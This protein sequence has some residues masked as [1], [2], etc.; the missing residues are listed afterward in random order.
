MKNFKKITIMA[1]LSWVL[2]VISSVL[3][4]SYLI[5]VVTA[6]ST[7]ILYGVLFAIVCSAIAVPAMVI[8]CVGSIMIIVTDFENKQINDSRILW[9]LLSLFLLGPIGLFVFVVVN[10][11]H[12]IEQTID[13]LPENVLPT[14]K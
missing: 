2:Y 12:A 10:K 1:I 4:M 9:G 8:S 13:T 7:V 14:E 3:F 5:G 6:N 11:K